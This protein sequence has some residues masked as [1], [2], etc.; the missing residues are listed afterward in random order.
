MLGDFNHVSMQKTLP[1]YKPQIRVP[2]RLDKTLDHC[3]SS[4]T[5]AYQA[6]VRAPIGESDHNIIFL[7]PKYR[8]RLK[9][10][11]PVTKW[12]KRSSPGAIDM[13]Q[14]CFDITDWDVSNLRIRTIDNFTDCVMSYIYFCVSVCIPT[15]TITI[16]RYTKPSLGSTRKL[17][18][19]VR[20]KITL[21]NVGTKSNTYF[22]NTNS[23]KQLIQL[24]PTTESN[25]KQTPRSQ[26]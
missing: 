11:K 21:S 19:C 2:T 8:Q 22:L 12:V 1:R 25:L 24:K 5:E 15:K 26:H 18:A 7:V 20:R 14:D 9:T 3:Y 23:G 13:L 4:I 6:L 10:S 16:Y 17:S